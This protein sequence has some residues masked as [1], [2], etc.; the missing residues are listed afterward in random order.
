MIGV[1]SRLISRVR[2]INHLNQVQIALEN[3]L[4]PAEAAQLTP[5]VAPTLSDLLLSVQG[6]AMAPF[7]AETIGEE[8]FAQAQ[9]WRKRLQRPRALSRKRT[10][11]GF[12]RMRLL[13]DV[14]LYSDPKARGPKRLLI[15]FAG[16]A[17]RPM[18]PVHA[19]LQHLYAKT[20]DVL[21]LRDPARDA[22]RSGMF[23]IGTTTEEIIDTLPSLIELA[24]YESI[25][26]IGTSGGG[27][28]ALI[29]GL[30]LGARSAVSAGGIHPQSERWSFRG[31]PLSQ[32]LAD[33]RRTAGPRTAILL[34]SGAQSMADQAAAEATAALVGATL[35]V[36][37]DSIPV[38]HPSL[39]HLAQ[40][41]HLTQVLEA[42]LTAN[43]DALREVPS[44]D[45][46]DMAPNPSR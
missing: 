17:M 29:A 4:T 3:I 25:N 37:S 44:L 45:V 9:E 23:G 27:V 41:R 39:F 32:A 2:S 43:V 8:L 16:N 22:Y 31:R 14:L 34:V 13:R 24:R 19:F 7:S 35:L 38:R 5:G 10:P 20:T 40:Q 11:E 36:V 26:T 18:M 42:M 28:P 15:L 33:L 1:Y 21:F 46:I 6:P 12:L 30:T